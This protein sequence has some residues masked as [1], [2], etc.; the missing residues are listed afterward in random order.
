MIYVLEEHFPDYNLI[1]KVKLEMGKSLHFLKKILT[2]HIS[3]QL[4]NEQGSFIIQYL[5]NDINPLYESLIF[6]KI[7]MFFIFLKVP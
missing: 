7:Q 6:L 3:C 2:R 4:L 5:Q 1:I